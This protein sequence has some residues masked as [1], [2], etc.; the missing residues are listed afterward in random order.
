[1]KKFLLFA[2]PLLFLFTAS[3]VFGYRLSK[4]K[5]EPVPEVTLQP[6]SAIH[7]IDEELFTEN[8]SPLSYKIKSYQGHIALFEVYANGQETL[9][10]E[11]ETP[12]S[13][14]REKDIELLENG[15][16]LSSHVL[17]EEA[18]ENFIN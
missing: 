11:Y 3:A 4:E 18:L 6:H 10:E 17:A 12:V 5:A 8:P 9:L 2:L 1:M 7:Y 13:S 14:L 15:I 16:T